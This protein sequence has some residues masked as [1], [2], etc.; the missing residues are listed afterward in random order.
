MMDV[1]KCKYVRVLTD[2]TWYFLSKIPRYFRKR[3]PMMKML[4]TL[5][6]SNL[7]KDPET[8]NK[9]LNAVKTNWCDK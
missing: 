7:S 8:E 6:S 1:N 9:L 2:R 3:P 4:R 5:I